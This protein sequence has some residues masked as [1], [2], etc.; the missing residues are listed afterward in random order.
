MRGLLIV[1]CVV[2][3][4]GILLS[5]N[6]SAGWLGFVKFIEFIFLGWYIATHVVQAITFL[7]IA[8]PVGI[9]SES[10]LAI[11]Q[12]L[13]QH[14]VGG[15]WYFL[16]ERTFSGTTPG[17]ANASL[18][19]ELVMRPYAT[20]PHPNV[21]AGY[22]LMGLLFIAFACREA[23][24]FKRALYIGAC[25]IG[26]IALLLTLSRTSIV[27]GMVLGAYVFLR[28]ALPKKAIVL[29]GTIATVIIVLLLPRF[30][31]TTIL[32]ES[33]LFRK[34]LLASSWQL[35]LSHPLLGVGI[36]NFLSNLPILDRSLQIQPVHNIYALVLSETGLFGF[37]LTGIFVFASV[38]RVLRPSFE[39]Q[40]QKNM[41]N[42]LLCSLFVFLFVGLEDHY[43]LTLQQG[44]LLTTLIFGICW[45]D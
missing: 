20:F 4:C 14:S 28:N 41:R 33:F 17:I 32:G 40:S 12:F 10:I 22:L 18:H 36:N 23:G 44:Q 38:K 8:F 26:I 7:R 42:F 6:P 11:L 45:A 3:M 27:L 5:V 31:D 39:I 19:G 9:V 21:L 15:V 1:F 43:F 2:L 29:L 34:Q 35:F 13:Q 30:F 16:G 25:V 37:C 24:V